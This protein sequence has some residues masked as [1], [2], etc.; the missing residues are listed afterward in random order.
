MSKEFLSVNELSERLN[1]KRSTLYAMTKAGKIPHF[2]VNRLIRFMERE[3]EEWMES[4]RVKEIADNDKTK[5]AVKSVSKPKTDIDRIIWNA[6]D[7]SKSL[8]Y[9]SHLGN[10]VE[11]STQKGGD[12]GLV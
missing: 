1:I 4:H 6:I 9:N 2:R 8:K 10:Q 12:H 11:S 3:V 5:R 7:E